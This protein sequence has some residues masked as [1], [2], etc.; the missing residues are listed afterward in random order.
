MIPYHLNQIDL[1]DEKNHGEPGTIRHT[2][3]LRQIAV[4]TIVQK[5]ASERLSRSLNTKTTV[6]AQKYDYKVGDKVDFYR[7]P[8]AKDTSGWF[9][10]APVTD[11]SRA[12]RG[13]ISIR[14]LS[15][16]LEVQLTHVRKHL[17]FLCFLAHYM[18]GGCFTA[19]ENC[20][21]SIRAMIERLQPRQL[22]MAGYARNGASWLLTT[23]PL[24]KAGFFTAVKFFAENQLHIRNVTAVRAGVGIK[25][26]GKIQG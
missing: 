10:P 8:S 25:A 5:S 22:V 24:T 9:G 19:H 13:I 11:V 6:P 21:S 4:Q 26:Y 12:E 14:W 15:K 2:H 17:Y 7:E 16:P 18:S 1:P 20:W 23:N 3:R